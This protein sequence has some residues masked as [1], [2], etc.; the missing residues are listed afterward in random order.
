M[1]GACA[2]A[3]RGRY[4]LKLAAD[5]GWATGTAP[6][7]P[8]RKPWEVLILGFAGSAPPPPLPRRLVLVCAPYARH[9]SA[10]P[11]LDGLLRAHAATHLC[12]SSPCGGGA[13]RLDEASGANGT[14]SAHL[15]CGA[16][17]DSRTREAWE[18]LAKLELY[19]RDVRAHWHACGDEV[20]RF[21]HE[22]WL[23]RSRGGPG[24]CDG[25]EEQAERGGI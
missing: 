1:V 15:C 13:G 20:L 2:C 18:A 7:S 5:G 9:H 17:D 23:E 16:A 25:R 19:A 21:R 24:R 14:S 4:W 3:P 10:K 11:C 12:G 6:T 22:G 8:H